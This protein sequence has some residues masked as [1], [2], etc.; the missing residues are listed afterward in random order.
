V[1]HVWY[2]VERFVLASLGFTGESGARYAFDPG[3]FF[4]YQTGGALSWD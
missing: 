1:F 4:D 2:Y 3:A